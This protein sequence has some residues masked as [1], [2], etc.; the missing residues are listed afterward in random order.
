MADNPHAT[1]SRAEDAEGLLNWAW[2]IICNAGE[3]DWER[4]SGEWQ[5][6]ARNFRDAYH[7]YLDTYGFGGTFRER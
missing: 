6:V 7:A 1:G 4:E 2:T 3:G 5:L